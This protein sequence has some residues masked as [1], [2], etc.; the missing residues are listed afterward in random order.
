MRLL[1][2]RTKYMRYSNDKQIIA[3]LRASH[4][5]MNNQNLPAHIISFSISKLENIIMIILCCCAKLI[6]HFLSNCTEKLFHIVVVVLCF[7]PYY[8]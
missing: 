4:D 2:K 3:T 6:F 1:N 8:G 5:Y 7:L